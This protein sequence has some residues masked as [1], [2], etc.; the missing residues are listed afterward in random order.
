MTIVL[1]S[2]KPKARKPHEPGQE[3]QPLSK[4]RE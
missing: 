1:H 4:E 2:S 3:P